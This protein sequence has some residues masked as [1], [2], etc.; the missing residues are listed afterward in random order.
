MDQK[1]F[2]GDITP[3]GLA[4]ALI[5][6][7]NH[8]NLQTQFVGQGDRVL[9]QIASRSVPASGGRT[10]I[11]VTMDKVEDGVLVQLGEQQMLG[12]AASI[13]ATAL[14]A[15]QNPFS[16]LG[17]LDDLAQDISSLQLSELIWAAV[18]KAAEA[19]GASHQISER[20]RRLECVYCSAAV[21]VGEIACPSC[22]APMG[23]SQPRACPNCGFIIPAGQGI[24]PKCHSVF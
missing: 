1:T 5:A 12:V 17:R 8:G 16:L 22:G 18:Q 6:E 19:A 10:A 9:L 13:G 23:A 21:P 2:H 14:A 4:Q 20:L 24:C 15:W 3:E 11:T 7:F